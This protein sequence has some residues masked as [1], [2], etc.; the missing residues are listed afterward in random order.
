ME[1]KEYMKKLENECGGR[2]GGKKKSEKV[3][4]VFGDSG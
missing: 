4:T 2:R 3:I 1:E